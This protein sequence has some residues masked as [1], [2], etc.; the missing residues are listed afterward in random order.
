MTMSENP[1]AVSSTR[2]MVASRTFSFACST[3]CARL[4]AA[5]ELI[6]RAAHLE[7][8]LLDLGAD[9]GDLCLLVIG[10]RFVGI[11]LE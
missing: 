7:A 11:G 6:E 5:P 10:H 9:L 8:G 3:R 4:E 2:P 1:F